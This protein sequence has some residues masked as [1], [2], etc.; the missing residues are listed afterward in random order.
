VRARRWLAGLAVV[1]LLAGCASAPP[2]TPEAAGD[3]QQAR[4]LVDRARMTL[5][6]FDLGQNDEGFR[7]AIRKA[8]GVLVFPSAFRAAFL[9]GGQGGSGVLLTRDERGGWSGPAFYT[10]GGASVG[11]QAGAKVSEVVALVMT[12]RGVAA[13]MRPTVGLGADISVAVGPAGGGVGAGTAGLSADVLTYARSTGLFGGVALDGAVVAVRTDLNR[14]F[15][16]REVTP[17]QIVRGEVRSADAGPLHDAL[18]KLA[19]RGVAGG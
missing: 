10:L 2:G 5:E 8:R 17:E 16:D 4:Q 11:F 1:A 12:D 15:Y 7:D 6:S 18:A 13:L 3:R 14:A 9:V 19:G